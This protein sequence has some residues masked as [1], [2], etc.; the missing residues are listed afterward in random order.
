MRQRLN[1]SYTDSTTQ[2]LVFKEQA[3]RQCLDLFLPDESST[4]VCLFLIHG[5]GWTSSSRTAWHSVAEYFCARGCVSVSVGYRLAPEH[6]FP[7]QFED[8]R[9]AFAFVKSRA[10]EFGLDPQR[11]VAMGSSAGGHLAAMLATTSDDDA[12]GITPSMPTRETRPAAVIGLCPVFS[13]LPDA[14]L[15]VPD[16]ITAL[17]GGSP[18]EKAE[19]ARLAS[20]VERVT[21][22]TPPFLVIT[23][24]ADNVTPLAH[25]QH[26]AGVLRAAHVPV[27]LVVLPGVGHGFGYGVESWSQKEML[28]HSERFLNSALSKRA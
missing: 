15:N 18:V 22:D 10:E 20:P 11:M 1:L 7:A 9:L 3:D 2:K 28:A 17:L 19:L 25:Q 8:V 24:D 26:M 23:G 5:G 27:E 6:R 21:N 14:Q 13:V 12:L 16:C 4:G